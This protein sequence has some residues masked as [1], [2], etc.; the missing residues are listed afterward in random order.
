MTLLRYTGHPF[1]DIGVATITAM[2]GQNE[3]SSIKLTD[4]EKVAERLKQDYVEL[5]PLRNHIST[6][7]LNSWFVQ[8]SKPEDE[9]KQY[10]DE[11][12]FAFREGTQPVEENTNC[13]FF[14][15]NP[16]VLYAHRQHIPLLAGADIRNFSPFGGIGIPVCGV[17]LL[18]IHALPMGCLKCGHFLGF[19]QLIPLNQNIPDMNVKFSELAVKENQLAIQMMRQGGVDKMPSRGGFS[20]TRFVDSLL[21]AR[22]LSRRKRV[23]DI[24]NITGYFF[25]NFGPKPSLSLIRLDNSVISFMHTAINDCADGWNRTVRSGWSLEKGE[26]R[27]ELNDAKT[28]TRRNGLYEEL[29]QLPQNARKFLKRW[30]FKSKEWTLVE[31][32]LRKVLNME[33][34]R[35]DTYRNLGDQLADYM[36]KYESGTLKFYYKIARAKSSRELYRTLRAA[37]E[38][39]LKAEEEKPLFTYDE[40]VMAFQHPDDAYHAWRLACDLIAFR[41][42]ER[43]HEQNIDLSELEPDVADSDDEDSEQE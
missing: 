8:S 13:T 7:F 29:F 24:Q 37:A 36:I 40:V 18:A 16:A 30:I 31:I 43:L 38:R 39:M 22:Q 42:L 17:A 28:G 25:T 12:L 34:A 2:S 26:T 5:T 6:I 23:V 3:P 1:I 35:I 15:E 11:V 32:F 19:H 10:A 27:S 14:P 9:R 21:K 41:M 33:Q 4:L 20:R